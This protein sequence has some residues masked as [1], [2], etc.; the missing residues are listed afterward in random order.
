[1]RVASLTAARHRGGSAPVRIDMIDIE[2]VILRGKNTGRESAIGGRPL[3][4]IIRRVTI[5]EDARRAAAF[6]AANLTTSYISHSELQIG[7][8]IDQSTWASDIEAILVEEIDH[9]LPGRPDGETMGVWLLEEAGEILALAYLTHHRNERSPFSVIED[10]V[11][12][13]KSRGSGIGGQLMNFLVEESRRAGSA[14]IFL[15]SGV[16]ND[17]AHH[18][19]HKNNFSQVS[20]VMQ[21]ILD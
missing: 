3:D 6:F 14:S 11:V 1:M 17:G 20:I 19:F 15:E 4:P 7:R 10:M 13:A 12:A 18:F 9:R 8:A 5:N 16:N 21:K 2:S